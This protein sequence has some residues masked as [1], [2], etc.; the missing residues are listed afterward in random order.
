MTEA[1]DRALVAAV[2]RQKDERA[3]SILYDRH[4]GALYGLAL[5]LAGGD[6]AAATEIVHDAWVRAA[7]RLADFAGRSALRTW[8]S[9]FVVNCARERNRAWTQADASLEEITGQG[10]DDVELTGVFDRLELEQALRAIAPGYREVLV[11][12]DVEGY[13][14]EEIAELRGTTIGTSKSQ[15]A[16]ARHA[17]RRILT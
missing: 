1:D 3:F 8:L 17:L 6:A 4:T 11:L 7:E 5:R 13:S 14:H 10:G 15:L 2:V 16:R 12:H 9:G